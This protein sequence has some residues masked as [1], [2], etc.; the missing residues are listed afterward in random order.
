VNQRR[1]VRTVT[2]PGVE[3]RKELCKG[4]DYCVV[5]CPEKCLRMSGQINS[6]GYRYA[7][8]TGAGCN[9]CG[10]CYYNCPEP[11]AITVFK[12]VGAAA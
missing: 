5:S 2:A 11:G 3:I 1:E 9:G 12:K 10:I 6:R 7:T 8:Y 4:C